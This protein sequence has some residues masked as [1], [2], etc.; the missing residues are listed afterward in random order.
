MERPVLPNPRPAFSG[1]KP[2]L[3]VD[4]FN[5]ALAATVAATVV[6]ES[7]PARKLDAS[8]PLI[9]STF[10]Q[11][12]ALYRGLIEVYW[13]RLQVLATLHVVFSEEI[14]LEYKMYLRKIAFV[15]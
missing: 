11:L 13:L 4:R 14:E 7:G 5:Q 8:R 9:R 1:T 12:S 2:V 3:K 15:L 10:L 6:V